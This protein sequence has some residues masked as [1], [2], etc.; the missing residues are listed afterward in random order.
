M[1]RGSGRCSFD[2][3]TRRT[4]PRLPLRN[5]GRSRLRRASHTLGPGPA[6]SLSVR[7]R[8]GRRGW[9]R[10][11]RRS[12][13]QEP[14][15]DRVS[16][17]LGPHGR[18]HLADGRSAGG[19]QCRHRRRRHRRPAG[20]GGAASASS[21]GPGPAYD[22]SFNVN[23]DAFTG[24]VRNGVGHRVARRPQQR[25]HLPRRDLP[26]AGRPGWT[27]PER[28]LR[29]L[30]RAARDLGRRRRLPARPGDHVRRSGRHH[31]DHGIRRRG[32]RGREPLRRGLQPRARRQPDR[33]HGHSRPR[34]PRP[35][36]SRS[37]LR[38]T[39]CR[40]IT[41]ST[42]TSSCSPIASGV[43]PLG[44]ATRR[45]PAAGGFDQHFAHMRAFWNAQLAAIA[46]ISVPDPQLVDAYKSGFISTQITR[47]GEALDTGVNGY[48]SEYSHDVIG[49]LTN[50]F[51]QGYDTDAHALLT[52]ARDAVG[53]QGQYVDGLWTYAVPW[54]VY[55]LKTGDRAFVAQNFA[56][57]GPAGAAQ[58]SIEDAAHAIAADRTGPMGTMEATDDIDTQG[59]WT[60]DDYES[61]L[62]LAAY[63]YLATALGNATEAAWAKAQYDSLLAA[64]NTVLGADHQPRPPRLPALLPP[65]AQHGQ[66]LRQ[67]EGRQLDLAVRLR[68]L[69]LGRVPP[70][71]PTQRTRAHADRL[72]LRLRLRPPPRPAPARH[73]RRLPDRLLLEWLRRRERR[74][75]PG[76]R[77]PSRPGDPELQIHAGQQPERAILVVGELQRPGPPLAV[78]GPAPRWSD[79]ASSPHAWGMAGANKVLL[80]SLVAQEAGGTL[81]RRPRGTSGVAARAA[82]RSRSPTSRR[83]NGR[84]A[85]LTITGRRASVTLSL[86]GRRRRGPV[87]FQL[88]SFVPNIAGTSSAGRQAGHGHR[89]IRRDGTCVTL[90]ADGGDVAGRI[91][92]PWTACHRPGS[93]AREPGRRSRGTSAREVARRGLQPPAS[94]R[95]EENRG[96][97][98]RGHEELPTINFPILTN[99]GAPPWLAPRSPTGPA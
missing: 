81:D 55:L 83:P 10:L 57:E 23:T 98:A 19:G 14:Q 78:G 33:P 72:H 16:G 28:G 71:G 62:G 68:E 79:K 41:P 24:A 30:R 15:R 82:R 3:V 20:T 67:P 88:P 63:G 27:V 2:S 34:Q 43:P 97:H 7:C 37:T 45:S 21:P 93:A 12:S 4:L 69:G 44:P 52:E 84:R 40:R 92:P 75:R 25:G 17:Y 74:R 61:L 9:H 35:R 58:P 70:G 31:L 66:P 22:C 8:R 80:D 26:R 64:T 85:G 38:R 77:R 46:Q 76:Q 18:R 11:R 90:T 47:S 89:P 48:E 59:S 53:S 99:R 5:G 39:R 51:T 13:A 95:Q 94:R 32:R 86:F 6:P 54:A 65:S 60:T 96:S 50:L 56:S 49:I 1:P 91:S 29:H 36:W 73:H 87:L 42:T